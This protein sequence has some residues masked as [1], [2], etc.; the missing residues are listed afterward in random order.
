MLNI[1]G[2]GNCIPAR[3]ARGAIVAAI[4]ALDLP[5]G[6]AHRS[7]A[8][9]LSCCIQGNQGDRLYCTLHRCR[10]LYI[11]HVRRRLV[12][13]ACRYRC[14]H[15]RSHVRQPLRYGQACRKLHRANRLL[16]IVR[17]LWEAS[18]TAAWQAPWHVA[19]FSF[20]SGKYLSVGEGGALHSRDADVLTRLSDLISTM[21]VPGRADGMCMLRQRI[22]DQSLG[23]GLFMACWV[24]EYGPLQ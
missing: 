16:R 9:L 19:A 11:M 17:S 20:R 18:M 15:R 12:C 14:C 23:A 3:S 10:L 21:P 22:F 8:V 5:A 24:I 6:C 7:S 1:P 4:K 13:K 2:L